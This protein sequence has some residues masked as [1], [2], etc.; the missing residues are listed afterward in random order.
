MAEQPKDRRGFIRIPFNTDAEI[1]AGEQVLRSQNG[2]DISMSGL[3]I[4]TGDAVPAEGTPCAVKITLKSFVNSL[5]IEAKGKIIRSAA[6]TLAVQFT[7]LDLDSYHHLRQLILNNTQEP[8]KA[9]QEFNAHWGIRPP[10]S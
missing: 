3:R 6:G 10:R 2:I 5:S 1:Q 9:E 4:T 8:E 7:E